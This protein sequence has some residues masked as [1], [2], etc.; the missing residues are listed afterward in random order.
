MN[1]HK[2]ELIQAYKNRPLVGGVCIIRNTQ[3]GRYLLETV[4]N[5]QGSQNRFLFAQQTNTCLSSRLQRD[6]ST[7]GN[8]VFNF[9]ILEELLQK[10]EQTVEEFQEELK[11]LGEV[12]A[13]KFDASLSY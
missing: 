9:E 7:F 2:K 3:N 5:P 6:W 4:T 12:W 10:E 1:E 8:E 11:I 13:E